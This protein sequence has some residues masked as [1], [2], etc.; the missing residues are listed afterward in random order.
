MPNTFTL[1]ASSTVGA[2]GAA[3][4]TFS[5]IPQTYTDLC[6]KYSLRNGLA[7]TFDN[8]QLTFNS[9]SS[10]YSD[11]LVY[12]NGSSALS[13]SRTGTEIQ[14]LYQTGA[15][16]TASTFSNGEIY[17]PNYTG[18]TNKSVSID[19][20]TETNGNPAIAG[21]DAALWSN[22][23]AITSINL[24]GNNGNFVQ[25]STAYLYGIVSS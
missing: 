20:V 3:N 6:L 16:A 23:A 9:V 17:I 24:N 22:T 21:L 15:N 5:S 8:I 11:R 18:S 7:A 12:G 25:Y 10:G 1:I 13:A 2:G 19:S 4:I 14:Y